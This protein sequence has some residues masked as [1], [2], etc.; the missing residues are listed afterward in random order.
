MSDNNAPQPDKS[1]ERDQQLEAVIADYIRACETGTAPNRTEILKQHPELAD[2]LRQ[3]FGQ[4]D[5]MNHI[6]API[7]GFGDSLAQA[8]G[9]G[10][11]LSYVGNYELLEE[12]ARG[13]MGV[14]YKARQTTLGRIVAV[15]MI[16]SGRLASEQDV[17]R[18]QV[19]AQAAAGL[20]HPNI[21][22]IHE[23]GQHEGWHYF[24]MDYVEGRDLSK[25]LRENLLSAKQAATYV[26]Q[27]AEAIHY[28]HQ[29]GTL[30]RDL[31]PSNILIDNHDQVR[32]TDFGLAMRV[33][34]GNDLTHTGQIVGTPSY[35]PPEQAQGNR[36]LIGPCSDVYSLGA[37]LYECLTG[38]APFRADSVLKTI[39]QVIHAEAA[40]PRT[41][42]AAIPRDLETVCLK[43]L[44]K[45]PHH[46]YGTAQLLA[47]ELQRFLEGR[48][49]Q[50][51][52]IRL[53]ERT[54]R[55]SRR[56]GIVA[57]L[58][59]SV[60][61]SLII[62]TSVSIYFA[63]ESGQRAGKNSQLARKEQDARRAA[64]AGEKLATQ[65]LYRSL[66]A[67]ARANRLSR[68]MGQRF[69]SLEV[70]TEASRMAHAM[71]LPEEDFVE[72]RNEA[73]ACLALVDIRTEK[74]WPGWPQGSLKVDFDSDLERY[75]R[76]DREGNVSVR[77]VL[78]DAE[79]WRLEGLGP[80]EAWPTLSPD[81]QF[82]VVWNSRFKLWS[83]AGPD[84]VLLYNGPGVPYFAPDNRRL[85]A[86]LPQGNITL[87][88][89]PSG[90]RVKDFPGAWSRSIA[91]HPQLNQ[92]AVSSL[93]EVRILDIETGSELA[94][95]PQ[96]GGHNLVW[97]P[98][99]T[100]LAVVGSDSNIYL[101]NVAARKVTAVLKGHAEG[102]TM[103]FNM[104]GD[105][106]ASH[107]W[108]QPLRLW[109]PQTAELL[110]QAPINMQVSHF[111]PNGH[112]LA[113]D[114]MGGGLLRI[115][116]VADA[117]SYYRTMIRDPVLGLGDYR[118]SAISP[119]GRILASAMGDGVAL[120]DLSSGNPITFLP[121]AGM[122]GA[123]RFEPSGV[124]LASGQFGLARWAIEIDPANPGKVRVGPSQQLQH[125][126]SAQD[127]GMSLDGRTVAQAM[128]W[129]GMVWQT[130]STDPPLQLIH[131]D[132]RFI[133]VSP[134]GRW[135]ATGSHWHTKVKIWDAKTGQP[136]H[137]LPVEGSSRVLFTSDSRRLATTYDGIRL[138]SVETGQEMQYVGDGCGS[139]AF[140]PD[141]S[142]LAVATAGGMIRLVNPDTGRDYAQLED[143]HQHRTIHA[144]FSSDG[145]QLATT[146]QEGNSIH[147]WNLRAIRA[148]LSE[149]KLDWELPTYQP[150]D[151]HQPLRLDIA[152]PSVSPHSASDSS[153]NQLIELLQIRDALAV[154]AASQLGE[155][156][157]QAIPAIP[158]LST[159]LNDQIYDT[160][161]GS[162]QSAAASALYRNDV[163]T[164]EK[165][166]IGA[167]KKRSPFIFLTTVFFLVLQNVVRADDWPQWRGPN[168]NNVS[169][170][171]GLLQT[172]PEG[173]PPLLFQIEGLGAGIAAPAVVGNRAFTLCVF[174]G[175]EYVVAFN[176]ETGER[177]WISRLRLPSDGYVAVHRL[178]RWLSQR[179]TTVY[180]GKLY[181]VTAYGLLVCFSCDD[182]RQL[183]SKDFGKEYGVTGQT[184]GFCDYPLVDGDALIC[185]PGGSKATIV[186]LNR[187]TGDEVWR[188]LLDPSNFP[189][190]QSKLV[191]SAHTATLRGSVQGLD[192]YVIGTDQ[193]VYFINRTDGRLLA[194]YEAFHP[195]TAFSHTPL[196]ENTDLLVTNGYGG[197]IARLALGLDGQSISLKEVFRGRQKLDTFEDSGIVVDGKLFLSGNSGRSLDCFDPHT[198][199]I[200]NRAQVQGRN[201]FTCADGRLYTFFVDGKVTLTDVNSKDLSSL[202]SFQLPQKQPSIGVTMPVVANGKLYL[203]DDDRMYCF[204][205][206]DNALSATKEPKRVTHIAPKLDPSLADRLLPV[207]IYLPTPQEVVTRM[208]AEAKLMSGQKLVDLGSGDGR[209]VV[210]AAKQFGARSVGYEIDKELV[211]ISRA[212]IADAKIAELATIEASDMFKADL[213]D[214][215]VLA[216]Y[217]YPDVMNQLKKQI[218]KMHP[219]AIVV[220]HQFKF[221][222]IESDKAIEVQSVTGERHLIYVYKLPLKKLSSDGSKN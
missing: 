210:T 189:N 29:Q 160:M 46:R 155:L 20:Q 174:D 202:A 1:E 152:D 206:S 27:M 172:W 2:E 39:E 114:R 40:S 134:D 120:W 131:N 17:Q 218:E 13:G 104:T 73:I 124:L 54:W 12:I 93:T 190:R 4:H 140:S 151:S 41:L 80:D 173:G 91:F 64:V 53:V 128:L 156:G 113:V 81:G 191:R 59:G 184:W 21:V 207:P 180:D 98:D 122:M 16:V 188:K 121:T 148:R 119:N 169:S 220:S 132:A 136:I 83:V 57:G 198:G 38:R 62:G 168:R 76:L 110:F 30:H 116:E 94:R 60:V 109:N 142:I 87:Y 105:M 70:L 118:A 19:E 200:L 166:G 75:V 74:Q 159:A 77:R 175:I 18:F 36:S 6:A 144:V 161:H 48:P 137:E 179:T 194:S 153:G 135:V 3:F 201:A 47:E 165:Q 11:Q 107:G 125:G 55:W 44:Q 221:P 150:S 100:T 28:A 149:M 63:I 115:L 123:V 33:E 102:T 85:A 186:A 96:D 211:A 58:I 97:H 199:D 215:D 176:V 43:C 8:V 34:S 111:S 117:S 170:E 205:V 181:A 103:A 195:T 37:V 49:I 146:S 86:I 208:L 112:R 204:D 106:L 10:Q 196:F 68:R 217:L 84:P 26:R 216:I 50:A 178:M 78:D 187:H 182:G 162:L 164:H 95:L 222:G 163:F 126:G 61:L 145:S 15:K 90:K 214:V 22:S 129:G 158:A 219:G 139:I 35:M 25:I 101:W 99:G 154:T 133:D 212:K 138:W 31:K 72:L 56:N 5:R 127:M 79:L 209:I 7:R 185:V 52:P 67:Q 203:R 141:D 45:E 89:L 147:V 167:M 51:R 143:P 23:V 88:E 92:L 82:L 130:H 171:T 42:N 65:R 71:S 108:G 24:S 213:T 157:T 183:W 192:Y 69:Q 197:G 193:A 14:V 9:P 32:I 66:V 177:V